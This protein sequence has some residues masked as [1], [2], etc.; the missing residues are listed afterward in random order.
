MIT[1]QHLSLAELGISFLKQTP[2]DSSFDDFAARV[3]R[4]SECL[5]RSSD[6]KTIEVLCYSGN[7]D[8]STLSCAYRLLPA[9]PTAP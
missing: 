1:Q 7:I 5:A 6:P 9:A 3:Q 2:R 8:Q 4:L